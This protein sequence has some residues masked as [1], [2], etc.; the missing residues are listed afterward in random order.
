MTRT[1]AKT[2]QNTA[3]SPARL[4]AAPAGS[5][6]ERP[7]RRVVECRSGI[8][9]R[10]SSGSPARAVTRE[11]APE[12]RRRPSWI[13]GRRRNHSPHPGAAPIART[14]AEPRPSSYSGDPAHHRGRATEPEARGFGLGGKS[15]PARFDRLTGPLGRGG[16]GPR[17]RGGGSRTRTPSADGS[18]CVPL[19]RATCSLDRL[20]EKLRTEGAG[21]RGRPTHRQPPA[22][23]RMG[24]EGGNQMDAGGRARNPAAAQPCKP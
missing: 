20:S 22:A 11:R 10:A 19:H 16:L 24:R 3:S 13:S 4:P 17:Q 9:T 6:F 12:D 14:S 1:I 5:A 21:A 7:R 15:E 23:A 18:V 8:S 2:N